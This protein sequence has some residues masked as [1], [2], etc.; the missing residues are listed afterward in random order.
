MEMNL[1]GD[2]LSEN[3]PS[4]LKGL[5]KRWTDRKSQSGSLGLDAE[6]VGDVSREPSEA[7]FGDSAA[8]AGLVSHIATPLAGNEFE[9]Q[10][11]IYSFSNCQC[12]GCCE[13]FS[14]QCNELQFSDIECGGP[15]EARS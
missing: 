5:R 6:S 15:G 13:L 7:F 11:D 2:V 14:G 10:H 3:V 8:S 9:V 1:T 12:W 4:Q